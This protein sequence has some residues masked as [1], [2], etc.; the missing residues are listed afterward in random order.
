MNE[1][2]LDYYLYV[3]NNR[4]IRIVKN[5]GIFSPAKI[6]EVKVY[7]V[8]EVPDYILENQ[9]RYCYYIS[10]GARFEENTLDI[11][12][13]ELIDIKNVLKKIILSEKYTYVSNL[14]KRSIIDNVAH[15]DVYNRILMNDVYL[16]KS[17]GEIGTLLKA[18]HDCSNFT[19]IDT[20][21][22]SI[23]LMYEDAA[24]MFAY[25]EREK[26]AFMEYIKEENYEK[27]KEIVDEIH[28][29][30]KV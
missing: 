24:E 1:I 23:E 19:H 16:Y 25:L 4:I 20:T 29:K 15:N 30:I 5:K 10:G 13:I 12:E 14:L 8:S 27:A 2:G 11:T 28:K 6:P 26:K 3:Y 18:V 22:Q 7:I 21:I 17:T 9:Y